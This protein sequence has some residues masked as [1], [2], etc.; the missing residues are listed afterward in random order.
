LAQPEDDLPGDFDTA[1]EVHYAALRQPLAAGEFITGLRGRLIAALD[2]LQ[3]ALVGD[4]A[5]GVRVI[6]RRSEPWI[7]VPKLERLPEPEQLGALKDEVARRWGTLDLLDVLKEADFLTADRV[8]APGGGP[9][10]AR[11][12]AACSVAPDQPRTPGTSRPTDHPAPSGP[13]QPMRT[14]GSDTGTGSSHQLPHRQRD[15]RGYHM[16]HTCIR[17]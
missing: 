11:S 12:P 8:V 2:G 1:R 3:A 13:P 5:G 15:T 10:H 16:D 9:A 17:R 7:T 14:S 4:T 6:T